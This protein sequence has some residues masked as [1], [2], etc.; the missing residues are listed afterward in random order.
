MRK[1]LVIA[2]LLVLACSAAAIAGVPDPSH[3][4]FDV[5]GTGVP[6]Q[7]RFNATGGLDVL[8]VNLTLRD[9]FDTPVANCT[10]SATIIANTGPF[11]AC[12]DVA[13]G[14]SNASGVVT[15]TFSR[16]GGNGTLDVCVTAQCS[17]G[18][19]MGCS[20]I[21][22]TSPD[23]DGSCEVT[24][25]ATGVIDLGIFAAGLPPGYNTNADYDCDLDVDVIDLGTFASG[26]GTNCS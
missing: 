18:V 16:I 21:N 23:L 26:L 22:F 11:C 12:V 5:S 8:S 3:S 6:C 14:V 2:S 19:A 9:P 20:T 13:T 7:Y 17:G 25:S 15:L 4:G 24:G 1:T 10:T